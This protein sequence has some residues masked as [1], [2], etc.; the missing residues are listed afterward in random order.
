MMVI[1]QNRLHRFVNVFYFGYGETVRWN[2]LST[3]CV[4]MPAQQTVDPDQES[5]HSEAFLGV[6]LPNSN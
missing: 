4:T 2:D 6:I 5:H 3:V 1:K